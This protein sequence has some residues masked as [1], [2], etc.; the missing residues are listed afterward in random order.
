MLHKA[1]TLSLTRGVIAQVFL[2]RCLQNR[3]QARDFEQA[4]HI[5]EGEGGE[6][7]LHRSMQT[8]DQTVGSL[9]IEAGIGF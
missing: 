4:I 8:D 1:A 3:F 5:K 2:R 9:A 7:P 6:S